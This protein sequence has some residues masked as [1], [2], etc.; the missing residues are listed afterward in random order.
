MLGGGVVMSGLI[1][2][3]AHARQNWPNG[4]KGAVSLTYDDGYDSQ[5]ENVAP[6]LDHLGL[7][8]T[9]FLTVEN[10]DERLADW[11]ALARKGHE[12]GNHT[13]THP[14]R[15][16]GYSFERF[17]KEQIEPAEQYLRVNFPGPAKRCFAYPCGVEGLGDGPADL[18]ARRYQRAV[19]PN[20]FAARTVIGPANDPRQVLANRYF[21]NGYEP[22]YDSD[23]PH[24]AFAYLKT[25]S[26]KGHW[27]ILIFHEVIKRR[28]GEGDTSKAVHQ[29]ILERIVQQKLWCAPVRTVYAHL[30]GVA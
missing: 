2:Q 5:L 7:K 13:S 11:Q 27:A 30:A 8:A 29:A 16:R 15:L 1:G 14:C 25:A 9:F 21:L 17:L 19:I 23:S 18:R 12:I 28:T 6:L 22:T 26:D 3:S 10:I 4:A 20:F 24:S